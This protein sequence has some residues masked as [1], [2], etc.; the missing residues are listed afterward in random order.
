[1]SQETSQDKIEREFAVGAPAKLS[2]GNIRGSVDIQ[3]G[4]DGV[5]QVVAVKRLDTGDAERTEIVVE[6]AADGSVKVETRLGSP[7]GW[8]TSW[9]PCAVDYT[10]RVPRQCLLAARVVSSALLARGMT[11]EV[12]INAV[13]GEVT[14]GDLSGDLKFKTVSGNLIG[15]ALTGSLRLDT[16]SG[17]VRLRQCRFDAID[18]RTVS[19]NVSIE[20]PL[21]AGAQTYRLKSVSGDI[22]LVFPAATRCA[23]EGH[24][25]SGRLR[26]NLPSQ[27]QRAGLSGRR[28]R[29]DV[30][31][32][33]G[34]DEAA[35]P[36]Q[37]TFDSVSANLILNVAGDAIVHEA[38]REAAHPT[39]L[40]APASAS[41]PSHS[42][43]LDR[44]ARGEM[45]VDD[46]IG[47]LTNR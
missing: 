6:Q 35:S 28:W 42:E 18:A 43:I 25:L 37:V 1:M 31:A 5:I 16:V 7:A 2:V 14:L 22:T 33:E 23:V 20:T 15:D 11:G 10:V 8:F 30:S 27:P 34:Q 29:V 39:P 45:T 19:G 38:V 12:S 13:S 41:G 9:Q 44:V 24:S 26:T 36:A 3:A 17:G 21:L 40:P 47:V 4:P 46:A 32:G